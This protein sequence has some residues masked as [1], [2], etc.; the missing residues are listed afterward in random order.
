MKKVK[1][2]S[3][4]MFCGFCFGITPFIF[5]IADLERGF[6]ATGGEIFIPLI[7]FLLYSICKSTKEILK[8]GKCQNV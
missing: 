2:L 6:N 4:W 8:E 3:F 1:N 5:Q 7:P